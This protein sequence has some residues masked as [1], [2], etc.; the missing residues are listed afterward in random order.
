[1]SVK[2]IKCAVCSHNKVCIYKQYVDALK[3]HGD[4]D[5]KCAEYKLIEKRPD[6]RLDVDKLE[7]FKTDFRELSSIANNDSKDIEQEKGVC[8]I[9]HK[10]TVVYTC[11]KCGKRVCGDCGELE[12][13]FDLD[14]GAIADRFIC[15][16]CGDGDGHE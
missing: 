8:E 10:K 11:S 13:N 14:T 4:I 3:I 5:F 2:N 15:N 6:I 16:N 7:R 1:M 9:C 12:C